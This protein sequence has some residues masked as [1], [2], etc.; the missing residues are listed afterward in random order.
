MLP[1]FLLQPFWQS[2]TCCS[3]S[4]AV[5]SHHL[6]HRRGDHSYAEAYL[7]VVARGTESV[8]FS[9][10]GSFT[11]SVSIMGSDPK[12]RA[13]AV[14]VVRWVPFSKVGAIQSGSQFPHLSWCNNSAGGMSEQG[15]GGGYS[16]TS[17]PPAHHLYAAVL[18]WKIISA[19]LDVVPTAL[20]CLHLDK[21][22]RSRE[23]LEVAP[24]HAILEDPGFP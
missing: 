19:S 7:T 16:T 20:L 9:I 13:G 24:I 17:L 8:V 23:V 6:C 4:R 14:D 18:L 10:D 15:Q 22:P 5:L 3:G 1:Q 21:I 2:Y 12:V 11:A